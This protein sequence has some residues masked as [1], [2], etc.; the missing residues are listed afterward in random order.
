[1]TGLVG[2]LEFKNKIFV[3]VKKLSI[4]RNIYN[5]YSVLVMV[6][7]DFCSV[8]TPSERIIWVALVYLLLM[9]VHQC[10]RCM[11]ARQAPVSMTAPWLVKQPLKFF[12]GYAHLCR[13][14]K[15]LLALGTMLQQ[16]WTF[17]L[18][19]QKLFIIDTQKF[20]HMSEI[21]NPTE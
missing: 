8:W 3:S 20:D 18:K 6:T 17:Q 19:Y 5:A 21:P 16:E 15:Q 7:F 14:G 2:V 10:N 13:I 1:M 4:F 12:N 11:G 9:F